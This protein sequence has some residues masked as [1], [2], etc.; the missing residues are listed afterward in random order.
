[1]E[2]IIKYSLKELTAATNHRSGEVKIGEKIQLI[3][4]NE[5]AIEFIKSSKSKF[6]LFGIPEDIGVRANFG[7]PGTTS[8]FSKF[9]SSFLNMQHNKFCKGSDVILLGELDVSDELSFADELDP[10]ILEDR[11]K[12]NELVHAIDKEVSH[13]MHQIIAAGKTPIVIGGG[14]NNAYGNIKGLALAKGKAA[15]VI[16]FD[17]HTDFRALEGRHSG[18]GFSYAYDEG[19]I[20]KYFIFGLHESYTSKAV[21]N[22]LKDLEKQIQYISYDDIAVKNKY[23]YPEAITTGLNFINSEPF[24]IEM[25]LDAIQ[26][27][28]SSAITPSGFSVEQARNFTFLV[29]Q[30]KNSC[31][32][33]ICEG[34]PSFEQNQNTNQT[35]KLIAYLVTDFIKSKSEKL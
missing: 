27:I 18:N 11:K 1:M 29:G 10:L 7:K 33:H 23:S 28:A 3:P 32:L 24:G 30:H 26:N 16:N 12:L 4:D 2:S 13:I 17:A 25:D 9:L 22:Q 14:H 20:K 31:Y 19:F 8:A 6:V 35:G 34:A 15:N 21:L 5:N